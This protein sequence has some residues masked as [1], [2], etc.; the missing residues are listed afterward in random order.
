MMVL[1]SDPV[2]EQLQEMNDRTHILSRISMSKF[3]SV[4][5]PLP[6]LQTQKALSK[7]LQRFVDKVNKA[8]E[9]L[10]AAKKDF[11]KKVFGKE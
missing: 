4:V 11:N 5:I 2:L 3:L 9:E 6:D 1:N 7:G 10:Y 8:E